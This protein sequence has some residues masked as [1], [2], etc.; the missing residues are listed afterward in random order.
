M[1]KMEAAYM[2]CGQAEAGLNALLNQLD[3]R[4]G[5]VSIQD[6]RSA[7]EMVLDPLTEGVIILEEIAK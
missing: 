7:L 4:F 6:I 5:S 2:K 3:G 1:N